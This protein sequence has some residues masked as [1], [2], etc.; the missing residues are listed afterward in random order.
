MTSVG[1]YAKDNAEACIMIVYYCFSYNK[2]LLP[3]STFRLHYLR[4]ATAF[5]LAHKD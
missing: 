2:F 1:L 4:N 3:Q 5:S